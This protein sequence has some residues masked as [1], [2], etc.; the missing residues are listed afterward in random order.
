MFYRHIF[1]PTFSDIVNVYKI[2]W[3]YGGI[4]NYLTLKDFF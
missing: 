1:S 2:K 3:Q 4:F